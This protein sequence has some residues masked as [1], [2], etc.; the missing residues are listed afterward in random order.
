MYFL[1]LIEII[2]G[3]LSVLVCVCI[4]WSM[5]FDHLRGVTASTT[6]NVYENSHCI[7]I[8]SIPESWY[9]RGY[10]LDFTYLPFILVSYGSE[11]LPNSRNL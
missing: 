8:I 10:S 2:R 11:K 5:F 4:P 7:W 1:L 6:S 9:D 3:C